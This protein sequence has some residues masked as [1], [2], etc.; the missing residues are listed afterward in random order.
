MPK[1][2]RIIAHRG[3]C[4]LYPENT[5][6]ALLAALDAGEDAVEFDV[7]LSRDGVPMVF[8]DPTLNRT[9]GRSGAIVEYSAKELG[10]IS[11]HEPA[12]LGERYAGTPIPTLAA[13]AQGLAAHSGPVFVELKQDTIPHHAITQ[14][15]A[16]VLEACAPL[17][18]R[19]VLISF[20]SAIIQV[21][22]SVGK[23]R[24]GWVVP[25]WNAACRD[26]LETLKPDFAFVAAE[27]LPPSLAPLWPGPWE[28]A[29][30]EVNDWQEASDLAR[31]GVGW[32]ET[33]A[34]AAMVAA[35]DR[36]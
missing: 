2:L 29:A 18:E 32:I 23:R 26:R 27:L 28:W 33:R 30:Y 15:V 4:E 14:A 17:G 9:T 21:A 19:A 8:H 34:V 6:P 25:D 1:S 7:Q 36:A 3:Y 22:R 24:I 12:R 5:L 13:V 31:R 16:A 10:K 20:D 35:R 11:A